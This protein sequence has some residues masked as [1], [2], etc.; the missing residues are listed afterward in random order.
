MR[1]PVSDFSAIRRAL[2]VIEASYAQDFEPLGESWYRRWR[3]EEKLAVVP[4]VSQLL[5]SSAVKC[6]ECGITCAPVWGQGSTSIELQ[7]VSCW[8]AAGHEA[9]ILLGL[10]ASIVRTMQEAWPSMS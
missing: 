7:G 2:D 6:N 9:L 3:A 8:E 1:C 5:R 10:F 4:G